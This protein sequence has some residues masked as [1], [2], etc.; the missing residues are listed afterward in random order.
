[1][2][3]AFLALLSFVL[4]FLGIL[5]VICAW[6]LARLARIAPVIPATND[7]RDAAIAAAAG[8]LIGAT[9]GLNRLFDWGIPNTVALVMLALAITSVSIPSVLWLAR[10][11]RDLLIR[12]V[13]VAT[14]GAVITAMLL[15]TRQ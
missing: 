14:T 5:A 15:V 13:A 4:V 3:D 2:S 1:V 6:E 7:R 8:G 10:Y 9:L 12:G 11:R